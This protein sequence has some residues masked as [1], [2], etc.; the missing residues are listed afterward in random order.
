MPGF[1]VHW[2]SYETN[3]EEGPHGHIQGSDPRYGLRGPTYGIGEVDTVTGKITASDYLPGVQEGWIATISSFFAL[4]FGNFGGAPVR[5]AYFFLGLAGAFL[6]Y[7]GNLFCADSRHKRGC[8]PLRRLEPWRRKLSGGHHRENRQ[9]P[10]TNAPWKG[11]GTAYGL[12]ISQRRSLADFDWDG[13]HRQHLGYTQPL[14]QG[15]SAIRQA[16]REKAGGSMRHRL[17]GCAAWDNGDPLTMRG[18]V[19]VSVRHRRA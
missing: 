17:V 2:I 1:T 18:A 10:P 13:S 12:Y 14:R 11:L 9:A 4:H 7:S 6:F 19:P 15:P 16:L 5:W 8:R 3:P